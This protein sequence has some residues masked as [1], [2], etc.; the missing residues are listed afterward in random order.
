MAANDADNPLSDLSSSATNSDHDPDPDRRE[1]SKALAVAAIIASTPVFADQVSAI[2]ATRNWFAPAPDDGAYIAIKAYMND[3][4][5]LPAAVSTLTTPIDAVYSTA[6][7]GR[8][9]RAAEA[10][11]A[12]QRTF[13]TPE[14]AREQWGEP[15]AEE[16]L[17]PLDHTAAENKPTAEGLLW[18]L[19]YSFLHVAKQTPYTS[20]AGDSHSHAKLL[21]LVSA[22]KA[23]PDPAPPALVTKALRNDWVWSSGA[24]WSALLLFGPAARESWNDCPGCGAGFSAPDAAAWANVNAF[25]ARVTGEGVADFWIYAIWALREALEE[26]GPA[27]AGH[28]RA[29]EAER[30]DAAVPAAAVWVIILGRGL[31]EREE[32]LEGSGAGFPGELW[33]GRNAFCKGRWG[34]WKE[35]FGIVA[36]RED[37]RAET[38][39]VARCA[40]RKMEE[41]EQEGPGEGL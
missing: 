11:A 31:W 2:A 16:D 25:V 9:I 12:H 29:E 20:T 14:Q 34:F 23:H 33:K 27:G 15:L 40:V 8:A 32:G 3:E 38:R 37:L 6:N 36:Q 13:W 17:P 4:I 21:T 1:T 35:R 30:L 28:V 19:W 24:L 5:S 39:E 41:V 18:T 22:L 7:H 10:T 26:R